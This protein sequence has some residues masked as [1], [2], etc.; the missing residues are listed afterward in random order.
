[1]NKKIMNRRTFLRLAAMTGAGAAIAACTTPTPQIIKETVV[2]EKP[3]QQTVV[4]EKEKVVQQTVVVEKEKQ[5][6]KVVTATP[7]PAIAPTTVNF[8]IQDIAENKDAFLLTA[9]AFNA[10]NDKVKV[11]INPIA[12]RGFGQKIQTM[13]AANEGPD[14]WPGVSPGEAPRLGAHADITAFIQRDIPK[15]QEYWFQMGIDRSMYQGKWYA[16]P[17][18]VG[19]N[20]IAYNTEMYEKFG[21][22]LPK[23]NWTFDDF[24]A[25]G[26]QLH[27]PDEG[28]YGTQFAG[29]SVLLWGGAGIPYNLGFKMQSDDG[30]TVK[31]FLDSPTSIEA[32]QWVI[33]LQDK[34]N[35]SVSGEQAAA[36]GGQPFYSGKVGI[37]AASVWGLRDLLAAKFKFGLIHARPSRRRA[38]RFTP[39]VVY[40]TSSCGAVRRTRKPT[41]RS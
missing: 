12:S 32:I 10:R 22:P 26:K 30:H 36:L 15:P 13:I 2:V 27:R 1:M 11:K 6:E 19:W 20:A 7:A 23:E 37:G 33:D 5:V 21:V 14:L 41:G 39:G 16:V 40:P 24:I 25:M 35:I 4:V 31:G 28:Y 3:V 29:S 38:I 8:F 18:D 9:D 34:H 17:K